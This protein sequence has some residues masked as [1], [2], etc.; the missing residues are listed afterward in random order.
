MVR[1]RPESLKSSRIVRDP[2]AARNLLRE[3]KKIYHGIQQEILSAPRV[4]RLQRALLVGAA[5][6]F[7]TVLCLLVTL[8]V[9]T[10]SHG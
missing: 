7:W 2:M 5:A 3:T 8:I 10:R 1:G 6:A 4:A 9:V